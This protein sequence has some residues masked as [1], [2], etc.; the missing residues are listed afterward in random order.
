M[1]AN[2]VSDDHLTGWPLFPF[3][4][5]VINYTEKLRFF[6]THVGVPVRDEEPHDI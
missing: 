2:S 6:S 5:A 3:Y 1:S 4:Y